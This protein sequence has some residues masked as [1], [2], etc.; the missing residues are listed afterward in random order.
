MAR[1]EISTLDR[2]RLALLH[3]RLG[4]A[5]ARALIRRTTGE[6]TADLA[7]ADRLYRSGQ[8]DDLSA[9]LRDISGLSERIGLAGLSRVAC[10]AADSLTR[11]DGVLLSS[12]MERMQRLGGRKKGAGGRG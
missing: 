3:A 5:G 11:N 1:D 10:Q 2:E 8:R 4:P 6:L 12:C 9:T 7:Q